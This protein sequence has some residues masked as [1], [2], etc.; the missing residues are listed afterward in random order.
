VD[1]ILY[2]AMSPTDPQHLSLHF[3]ID[4]LLDVAVRRGSPWQIEPH[5]GPLRWRGWHVGRP[6]DI[7]NEL[8]EGSSELT[9]NR[10]I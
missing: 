2:I 1:N 9:P 7:F 3:I 10:D 8:A 5:P 4:N 6:N